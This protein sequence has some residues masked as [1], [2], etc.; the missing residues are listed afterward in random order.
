M[1]TGATVAALECCSS[2]GGRAAIDAARRML[3][4]D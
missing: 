4:R 3:R 2:T 1:L